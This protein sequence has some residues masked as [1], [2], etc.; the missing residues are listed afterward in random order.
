MKLFVFSY[1]STIGFAVLFG[2]PKNSI[3]KSG[4]VGGPLDGLPSILHPIFR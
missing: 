2:I 4:F 1:L 3:I